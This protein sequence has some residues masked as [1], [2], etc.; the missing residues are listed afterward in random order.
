MIKH[1]KSLISIIALVIFSLSGCSGIPGSQSGNVL[2]AESFDGSAGLLARYEKTTG[3]AGMDGGEF[4][5]KVFEQNYLQWSLVK[6]SFSDTII[7]V[8]ARKTAGPDNNLYGV[9]CRYKDD[10]NFYFLAV[11]SDGY[12]GIGR[13]LNGERTLLGA[14]QMQPSSAVTGGTTVNRLRVTCSGST[15]SLEVNGQLLQTVEDQ[16]FTEGQA[17]LFAGEFSDTGLEIRFD[18]LLITRPGS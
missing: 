2:L 18:N 9:I 14:D 17:G 8:Q 13:M 11:S 1:G 12:Y 4:A 3:S 7:D 5:I 15:L 10:L 16:S 6:Q